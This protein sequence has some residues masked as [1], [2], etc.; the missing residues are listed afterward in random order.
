M[1]T[2]K[3]FIRKNTS[4]LR[5]K[6]EEFG[7]KNRHLSMSTNAENYPLLLVYHDGYY[8]GVFGDE[9][10]LEFYIDCGENE[11]LFLALATLRDDKTPDYQWYVWDDVEDKGEKFKQYIPGEPW[12]GWWWFEVHKA[13]VKELIE[14]FK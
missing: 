7:Y 1:F 13:S 3:C 6:L 14:H 10:G 12:P 5:K 4:E 8:Q 2:T 11:D 9:C